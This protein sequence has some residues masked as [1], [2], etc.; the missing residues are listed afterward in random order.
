MD[1]IISNLFWLLVFPGLLF[2]VAVGLLAT[3]IVR[4]VTAMIHHRIGP[5]VLQPDAM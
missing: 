2:T 3:W 5:P 1:Q 4:K